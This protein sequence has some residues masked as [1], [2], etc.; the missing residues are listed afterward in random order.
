[1]NLVIYH[2]LPV[3]VVVCRTGPPP[4]PAI[5][6]M[7][8]PV[9]IDA[10]PEPMLGGGVDLDLEKPGLDTKVETE[11]GHNFAPLANLRSSGEGE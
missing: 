6:R 7:R 5:D 9:F 10:S 1:M 11:L 3:T 2:E 8:R 4:A